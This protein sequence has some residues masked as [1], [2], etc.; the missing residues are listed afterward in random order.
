MARG[1]RVENQVYFK[2]G[3]VR[4]CGEVIVFDEIGSKDSLC[5]TRSGKESPD[6][7]LRRD[8]KYRL[9]LLIQRPTNPL[10]CASLLTRGHIRSPRNSEATESE[11][12]YRRKR[13]WTAQVPRRAGD[14]AHSFILNSVAR[15]HDSS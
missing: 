9:Q 4:D 12:S 2:S 6:R 5:D 13:S 10:E 8:R 3:V 11:C 1:E 15:A 7:M 14:A